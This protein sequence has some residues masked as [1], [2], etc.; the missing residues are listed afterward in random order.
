MKFPHDTA[1]YFYNQQPNAE[2][3]DSSE[4]IG[5][6]GIYTVMDDERNLPE[7]FGAPYVVLVE[8]TDGIVDFFRCISGDQALSIASEYEI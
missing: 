6:A 5:W 2:Y 3:G 1:K 8:R 4:G 7:I